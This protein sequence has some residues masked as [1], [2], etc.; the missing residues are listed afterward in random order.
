MSEPRQ[1][2][3]RWLAQGGFISIN[4]WEWLPSAPSA[5][6]PVLCVHGLTRNGRDFDTLAQALVAQGRRVLCPDLPGRGLSDPLRDPKGYEP[7]S[8]VQMLTTLLALEPGQVDWVG[9]SLGGLCGM[10]MA[11]MPGNAVRRLV[12][13]DIGPFV[14]GAAIKRIRD[15]VGRQMEFPDLA[16]LEQHLRQV[17]AGFGALSD[18]QWAHLARHSAGPGKHGGIRLRYDAA[19][20]VPM[21]G[22]GEPPDGD[23]WGLWPNV[24]QPV[25]VLR[26]ETSD[27][28]LPETAARMAERPGV[29]LEVIAGC[30]HA[31][32]LMDPA[33][34]KL[35]TDFLG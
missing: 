15:Y 6:P 25:L 32:A 10:L 19:I 27:L 30:G 16:A 26:G 23:M 33:Q 34:V 5:A 24:T 18:A 12:L 22:T 35:V 20:G 9:T 13:N 7:I 21:Q 28:L 11:M 8:Y 29:R 4:V 14:P 3:L 31:P 2:A 1:V 17:H